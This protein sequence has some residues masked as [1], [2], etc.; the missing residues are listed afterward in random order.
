MLDPSP[1]GVDLIELPLPLG[2]DV[3]V[4]AE[5]NRTR[6][7]G[8]LIEREDIGHQALLLRYAAGHL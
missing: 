6:A 8:A 2:N 4:F 7:G 1:L 3:S 5:K